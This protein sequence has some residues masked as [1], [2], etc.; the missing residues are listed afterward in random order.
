M[1]DKI[2]EMILVKREGRWY[3]EDLERML[4]DYDEG[5][6]HYLTEDMVNGKE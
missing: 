3:L 5:I 4:N 2:D 1:L 6:I